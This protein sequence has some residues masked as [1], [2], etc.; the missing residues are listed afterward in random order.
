MVLNWTIA[1]GT[2]TAYEVYRGTDANTGNRVKLS[3]LT[4]TATTYTDATAVNGT[5]YYYWVKANGSID[6]NAVTATPKAVVVP[7]TGGIVLTATAGNSSVSLNWNITNLTITSQEVYRDTDSNPSGR[8][9][10]SGVSTSTRTYT[11]ATAVNGTTYFYWI[12]ANASVNSNP[13]E[14]TPAGT[15]VV[16]TTRIEDTDAGTISYDGAIKAYPNADNGKTINL[17]NGANNQIIWNYSAPASGSYQLTFRYTRK[18]S[19]NSSVTILVNGISQTLSLSE[20]AGS[21]FTTSAITA[22][23]NS[24]TNTIILKS[25]TS[26]ESADIDWIEIKKS[27][28]TSKKS[29]KEKETSAVEVSVYPNPTTDFI[30]VQLPNDSESSLVVY[31]ATGQ[32]IFSKENTKGDQTLDL[33]KSGNGIH[34]VRILNGGNE[35]VKKIIKK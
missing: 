24:G 9:K 14:A 31:N 34:I 33:T 2:A 27:G 10:L 6:S 5:M 12:K 19:M 26:G 15:V 29:L 1:N 8:T 30:T 7:P 28:T 17:S 22:S 3:N 11:D 35:V 20:T 18:A 4:A 32:L 25:N 16:S 13:A 21:E 23:L